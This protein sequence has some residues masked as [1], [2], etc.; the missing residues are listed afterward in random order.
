MKH[1]S[2]LLT[3]QDISCVG[4][5]SLTVA[6][7]IISAFG[8]ECAILPTA[9]LS[10]HTAGFKGYTC[11]DLTQ[12]IP[13]IINHWQTENINFNLIYTGYLCGK[14]QINLVKDIVSKLK[15][16][17]GLFIVDPVMADHGKFYPG[18]DANFANEM[19]K[20]C[21]MAQVIIPNI[22]EACFLTGHEYKENYDK[23]YIEKLLEKLGALGSEKV[24]LTGVSFEKDKLGVAVYDTNTQETFYY[25]QTLIA[26]NFHGTGDVYSSC[27]AGGLSIGL[28]IEESSSLAVD[29]TVDAMKKSYDERNEHWYGVYFER[30]LSYLCERISA[31]NK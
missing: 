9:V 28:S 15:T 31:F 25:F 3:I 23:E 4:Q 12:E 1:N 22:T 30:S 11:K 20:L 2:R 6:L 7:P 14:E 18:F 17:N 29:F 19:A 10:T 8:T 5:C 16:K 13:S 24:I 21:G 26:H 27:V